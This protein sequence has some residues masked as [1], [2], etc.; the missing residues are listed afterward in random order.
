MIQKANEGKH[1][2]LE[3]AL[4]LPLVEKI[5]AEGWEPKSTLVMV[6][7]KDREEGAQYRLRSQAVPAPEACGDHQRNINGR[8]GEDPQQQVRVRQSEGIHRK[9]RE[10]GAQY[11][12]SDVPK[13]EARDYAEAEVIRAAP[14]GERRI[15]VPFFWEK[16]KWKAGAAYQDG[17]AWEQ[18]Y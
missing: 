16:G 2:E 11:R 1:G 8:I 4:S 13:F 9:D 12:L 15:T 14:T 10:Q 17:R 7:R 6:A 18:E 3:G 5:R